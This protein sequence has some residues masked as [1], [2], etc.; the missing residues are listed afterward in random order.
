MTKKIINFFKAN[1]YKKL[2]I[3]IISYLTACA[4]SLFLQFRTSNAITLIL[5]VIFY[6]FYKISLKTVVLD[7]KATITAGIEG[8][9]FSLFT[10]LQRLEGFDEY[11][12]F[13]TKGELWL[14]AVVFFGFWILFTMLVLMGYRFIQDFHSNKDY[15][16]QKNLYIV[17]FIC[18]LFIF[19]SWLPYYLRSFP[20]I[21]NSDSM[22]QISQIVTGTY[23]N[24]HPIVHTWFIQFIMEVGFKLF[25]TM[26]G[27]IAT[28][29]V[30]QM[31]IIAS[32]FSFTITVLFK[33]NIKSW[34][35]IA[36]LLFYGW[37]PYNVMFSFNMWKDSLFASCVLLFLV[38]LWESSNR[39][40][41]KEKQSILKNIIVLLFIFISALGVCLFRTN[42][43]YAFIIAFP[44]LFWTLYKTHKQIIVVLVCVFASVIFFKGPILSAYKVQPVDFVESL[45]I[46]IQQISRVIYDNEPIT[47]H[48]KELL[49]QIV[50]INKISSNYKP[51][52]SDPIKILI[53]EKENIEFLQEHKMDFFTL[54]LQ[55]GIE[56]P[57][58]YIKAYIDQ[59]NGYW[60]PDVPYWRYTDGIYEN[61]YGIV[62]S[63]F[64]S[65]QM[66]EKM[67]WFIW[68]PEEIPIYGLLWSPG[69]IVWIFIFLFG[70]Y[71]ISN[72]KGLL[73]YFMLLF[74]IWGT[75]LIATPVSAELRYI[76]SM[77]VTLPFIFVI[78]TYQ[79]YEKV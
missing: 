77:F 1:N 3:L 72:K 69:F 21:V 68:E 64:I 26:N 78:A 32:V 74:S 66:G 18:L 63:S 58:K 9:I 2:L 71:F 5:A 79:P 65:L 16:K 24:H 17:F 52:I 6:F 50:D 35:C 55:I 39:V 76:Y 23:K 54:W 53:R 20:G 14:L 60:F 37:I 62:P 7:K 44:F 40:L 25:G 8:A 33:R 4:F 45:S 19:L 57:I 56:Y 61:A 73:G 15:H 31:L 28:Y 12:H 27:A 47:N 22:D 48:Q 42:G 49:S 51:F 46:P 10:T 41:R 43:F 38:L 34:I 75:L 29:C 11:S 67:E 13:S 59:T 36:I 30:I 70:L